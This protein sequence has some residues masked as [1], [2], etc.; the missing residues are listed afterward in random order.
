MSQTSANPRAARCGREAEGI[1]IRLYSEE[2]FTSRPEF[3]EPEILRTSLASVILQMISAGIAAS[4]EEIGRFPFVEPPDARNI[5]DGVALLHELGAF[6]PDAPN[7]RSR[8]TKL[9]RLIRS[10]E[11]RVGKECRSLR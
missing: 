5:R 11:R 9:G 1:A 2:D 10:A 4:P 6:D 3:T 7:P 8:L